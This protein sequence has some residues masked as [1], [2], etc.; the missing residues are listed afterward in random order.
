MQALFGIP[1]NTLAVILAVA[2]VCALT[3][4]GILALRN[5]VFL[6]LG[7]RNVGRRRSRTLLILVGLMLGSA[8]ISAAL[9]TGDTLAHTVRSSA[10]RSLGN[11]DE[12]V[13][14]NGVRSDRN[15]RRDRRGVLRRSETD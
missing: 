4:V 13:A 5:R 11:T 8:L 15:D 2:F 12:I 9:N 10:I 1:T 14:V 6:R 7:I 3:V